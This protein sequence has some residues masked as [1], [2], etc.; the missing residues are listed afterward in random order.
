MTTG[1]HEDTNPQIP[2]KK[3]LRK[4]ELRMASQVTVFFCSFYL[5]HMSIVLGHAI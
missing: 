1:L 3:Y 2:P 5:Y 4:D